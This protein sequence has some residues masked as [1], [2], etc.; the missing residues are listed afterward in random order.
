MEKPSLSQE[1]IKILGPVGFKSPKRNFSKYNGHIL[2]YRANIC[3][4]NYGK[5]W[6]GDLDFTT[7]EAKL[8]KLARQFNLSFY[9][10]KELDSKFDTEQDPSYEKALIKVTPHKIFFGNEL[11]L[12]CHRN[13]LGKLVLKYDLS[14][15]FK[16]KEED[17]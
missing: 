5:I 7:D 6:H 1:L 2:I 16:G 14:F 12:N 8:K 4:Q 15:L 13:E 17:E 11:Q 3:V 10:L 9:I